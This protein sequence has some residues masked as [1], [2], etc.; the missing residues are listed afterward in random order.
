MRAPRNTSPAPVV[1]T[2]RTGNPGARC[3]RS[4]S[5]MIAPRAPR[6][7]HSRPL[8]LL[9]IARN[10]LSRSPRRS[11]RAVRLRQRWAASR[12]R[13][14]PTSGWSPSRCRSSHARRVSCHARRRNRCLFVHVV[15][16]KDPGASQDLAG[17]LVPPEAR[18]GGRSQRTIRS[19]VGW[20]TRMTANG[21]GRGGRRH[22]PESR[23]RR[24]NSAFMRKPLLSDPRVPIYFA[25]SPMAAA[26]H[27]AVVTCPP[28]ETVWLSI[29][30]LACCP[31]VAGAA[32]NRYT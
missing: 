12:T 22:D 6:V 25:R 18:A 16:V 1:S 3:R 9:R 28:H 29:R 8:C 26:V 30:S 15:D 21:L 17:D 5:S 4:P 11:A 23:P 32:G 13:R 24:S 20:T 31:S 19:P 14:G 10:A 2:A 27:N 7:T